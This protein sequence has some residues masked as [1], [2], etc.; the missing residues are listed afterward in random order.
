MPNRVHEVFVI[1]FKPLNWL[2]EHVP[3]YQQ[4][5]DWQSGLFGLM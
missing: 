1:F 3:A 5:L 4:Y 2:Y